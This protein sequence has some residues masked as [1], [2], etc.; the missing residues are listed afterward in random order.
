MHYLKEIT[1]NFEEA[2]RDALSEA[3]KCYEKIGAMLKEI[4]KLLPQGDWRTG[5][6]EEAIKAYRTANRQPHSTW[7]ATD[8]C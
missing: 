5:S 1:P 7:A 6:F 3:S 4:E 2:K 8:R